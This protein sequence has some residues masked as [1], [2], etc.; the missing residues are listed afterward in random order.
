MKAESVR[1]KG[2]QARAEDLAWE[3]KFLLL[4]KRLGF[5]NIKGGRLNQ[6]AEKL[7]GALAKNT[8]DQET[9]LSSGDPLG[10]SSLRDLS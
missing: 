2:P 7:L 5:V 1:K 6:G 3:R 8:L 9:R 10:A 4:Q